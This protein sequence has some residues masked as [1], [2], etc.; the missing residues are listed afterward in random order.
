MYMYLYVFFTPQT[1]LSFQ[2]NIYQPTKTVSMGSPF[3]GIMAEIFLQHLEN[4]QL[5]QI[6]DTNNTIF[7]TGYVDDI[8]IIYDTKKKIPRNN[9]G[10][11]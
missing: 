3:S 4:T 10:P 1:E 8:L 2:V 5:K 7:Y 11:H 9:P 6:I